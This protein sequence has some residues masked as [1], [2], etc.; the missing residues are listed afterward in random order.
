M[1]AFKKVNTS[2]KSNQ[3]FRLDHCSGDDGCDVIRPIPKLEGAAL[4][5]NNYTMP[6]LGLQH[7]K[8]PL[9]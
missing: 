3:F 4:H 2:K 5:I 7:V 6:F 9:D 1:S 8:I